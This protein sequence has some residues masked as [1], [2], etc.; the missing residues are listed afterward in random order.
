MM[1]T[2]QQFIDLMKLEKEKANES[3][4]RFTE[5]NNTA[6]AYQRAGKA[7]AFSFAIDKAE[8][9]LQAQQ[10]NKDSQ[11]QLQQTPCTTLLPDVEQ[12]IKS[13]V[14]WFNGHYHKYE[15]KEL[16]DAISTIKR[17]VPPSM[18]EDF[19]RQ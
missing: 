17:L 1:N 16:S 9:L 13:R 3:C 14:E 12:V 5:N 6:Y 15:G 19:V 11:P 2:L 18:F 7:E 4:N 8:L 10:P